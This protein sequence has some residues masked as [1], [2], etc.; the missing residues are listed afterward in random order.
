MKPFDTTTTKILLFLAQE[1]RLTR[2]AYRIALKSRN[3]SPIAIV[4]AE[5]QKTQ[6]WNTFQLAKLY[7][8]NTET[9]IVKLP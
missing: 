4:M 2:R 8:Y 9:E 3:Q 5:A 7:A 6:A 1:Y